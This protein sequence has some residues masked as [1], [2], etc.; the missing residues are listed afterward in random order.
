[1]SEAKLYRLTNRAFIEVTGLDAVKFLQNL[2]TN[3]LDGDNTEFTYSALLSPQGKYLFDFFILKR[4]RNRL[5]VDILAT[6][7]EKFMFRLKMYKLRSD[8]KIEEV[9]GWVGVGFSS[10]P[11]DAFIDPRCSKLGWRQYFLG[12]SSPREIP[13]LNQ[14]H[15]EKLRVSYCIP[16]TEIELVSNKTFILEAGFERLSGVSFVK[17]CYIGQEVTARMHHKTTL[18]KGLAKVKILG[19]IDANSNEIFFQNKVIGNLFTRSGDHAIAYLKFVNEKSLLNVGN[20]QVLVIER[21]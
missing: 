15:F 1:M 20:A 18:Q 3:D 11:V 4:S 19:N 8:V 7:A 13:I 12:T 14:H 21:F 5:I 6:A 2:T 10:K 9:K 16:E 17:G